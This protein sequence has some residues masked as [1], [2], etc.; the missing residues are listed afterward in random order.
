MKSHEGMLPVRR[1]SLRLQGFDYSL[2]GCYF[3]TIV[4]QGRICRFGEVCAG[5]MILNAA[6]RMVED[7]CYEMLA[8]FPCVADVAHVIMPNHVHLLLHNEGERPVSEMARWFKS[9]TTNGYIHGV[10]EQGWPRF[11]IRL[12]QTRFYDVIIRN[13]VAHQYVVEYIRSNPLR[14]TLD[15]LNSSADLAHADE[16]GK[17]LH[18][19]NW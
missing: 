16:I 19:I 14:W 18:L 5:E 4:T 7:C 3:I 8:A 15:R 6:G 17:D 1:N 13:P 12:W 10:K 11:E 9:K 2:P